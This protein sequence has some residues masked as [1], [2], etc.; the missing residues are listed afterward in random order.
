[1]LCKRCRARTRGRAGLGRR[2]GVDEMRVTAPVHVTTAHGCP[3]RSWLRSSNCRVFVDVK[4]KDSLCD[5]DK[6][7][8]DTPTPDGFSC[9]VSMARVGLRSYSSALAGPVTHPQL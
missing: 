3:E 7:C 4:D 9:K 8:P 6:P 5:Y 1:M 2:P